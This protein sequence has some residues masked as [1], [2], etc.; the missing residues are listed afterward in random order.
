M[1]E[2]TLTLT[3]GATTVTTLPDTATAEETR[4]TIQ[5]ALDQ[6]SANATGGTVQLSAGI[7]VVTAGD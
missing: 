4:A 5:A 6:A 1:R 2:I 3:G 7:Y